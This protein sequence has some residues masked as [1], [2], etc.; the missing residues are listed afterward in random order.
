[1]SQRSSQKATQ[2][3][4]DDVDDDDDDID[5]SIDTIDEYREIYEK[6]LV[7]DETVKNELDEMDNFLKSAFGGLSEDEEVDNT[8]HTTSTSSGEINV[9][10]IVMNDNKQWKVVEKTIPSETKGPSKYLYKLKR[11][12]N[13]EKLVHDENEIKKINQQQK[14][15][16]QQ[17]QLRRQRRQR[18]Q[19]RRQRRQQQQQ[20]QIQQQQQQIQQQP[21]PIGLI[22]K[23]IREKQKNYNQGI[24][25]KK[26]GTLYKQNKGGGKR[27]KRKRRKKKKTRRKSKRKKKT[28]KRI[29][30][31]KRTRRK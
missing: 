11:N 21:P 14:Q 25:R 4:V 28:R 9:G 15:Q 18:R 17:Q 27:T 29:K 3:V 10:D 26:R 23:Q 12:I 16:I 31:K 8:S 2:P 6:S 20:Q 5:G 1:M 22:L 13:E 30:R 24:S 7:K 19:Q